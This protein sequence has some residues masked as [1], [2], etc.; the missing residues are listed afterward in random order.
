M[1]TARLK[2]EIEGKKLYKHSEEHSLQTGAQHDSKQVIFNAG[3]T[4]KDSYCIAQG[5][6]CAHQPFGESPETDEN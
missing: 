2:T 3:E 5:P 4:S 1:R 6:H